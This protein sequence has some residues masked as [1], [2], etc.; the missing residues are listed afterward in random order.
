MQI[1][2]TSHVVQSCQQMHRVRT[3]LIKLTIM[4]DTLDLDPI[5]KPITDKYSSV[6]MRKLLNR[7]TVYM[8]KNDPF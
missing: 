8:L 7:Y 3:L 6:S 1:K 2:S 4:Q 5:Q